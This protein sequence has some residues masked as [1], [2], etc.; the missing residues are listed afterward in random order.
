MLTPSPSVRTGCGEAPPDWRAAWAAAAAEPWRGSPAEGSG[1][2]AAGAG[3]WPGRAL[4]PFLAAPCT[5]RRSAGARDLWRGAAASSSTCGRAAFVYGGPAFGR[6][7]GRPGPGAGGREGGGTAAGAGAANLASDPAT[8]MESQAHLRVKA[9]RDSPGRDPRAPGLGEVAV[10]AH[11]MPRGPAPERRSPDAGARMGGGEGEGRR[12]A[13][14]AP[15]ALGQVTSRRGREEAAR[16]PGA[17]PG[18]IQPSEGA[19]VPRPRPYRVAGPRAEKGKARGSPPP[20][21]HTQENGVSGSE[22][23]LLPFLSSKH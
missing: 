7:T 3:P 2:E 4:L 9:S 22:V 23:T 19:L 17:R 12:G 15:V 11:G 13:K 18:R 6:S 21:T 5:W 10:S 16:W 14:A 1:P 20:I 8:A